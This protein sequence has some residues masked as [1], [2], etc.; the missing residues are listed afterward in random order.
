MKRCFI[1]VVLAAFGIVNAE[2]VAHPPAPVAAHAPAPV[3]AHAPAPEAPAHEAPVA[4]EPAT[5]APHAAEPTPVAQPLAEAP[6]MQ[7]AADT[8]TVVLLV[9]E[10][11]QK[12]KKR[13][14]RTPKNDFA[15]V[16]VPANFE[17]Q[18]RKVMPLDADGWGTNNLDTWWGRANLM[19]LTESENFVGKLH[20]RMYPGE[21]SEKK[22]YAYN[23]D[24]NRD[25]EGDYFQLYEAWAWHRGDYIN[26]KIG[27]WDNTTRFGSKTFGGYIDAK[28]D[29]DC[30]ATSH[31][32]RNPSCVAGEAANA[33]QDFSKSRTRRAKGFMSTY[34][35]ESMVQF[36]LN[37]FS[38][39]MSLDIALISSDENLNRGDLR[40]YFSFKDL[41]G[42]ENMELGLGYR[43]NV[44]DEIFS[45]YTDVTHTVDLGI[46]MPLVKDVGLLKSMSLF[47]ETALIGLDDHE[48]S[49]SRADGGNVPSKNNPAFP[50][51]GGLDIALYRGF[52]KVVIEAEYDGKR[53]NQTPKSLK[54]GTENDIRD[55]QG[56]IYVQKILNDR[57]TLNLGVQS[58]HNT[59]DFSFAARLQGR[60]N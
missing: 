46:R 5:P 13:G 18:G 45:R 15:V 47:L 14:S 43:S 16:D 49:E 20:L 39:N 35:P 1:A 33:R 4:V 2:A 11:P 44:F 31:D 24:G 40:A 50:V 8:N 29:K 3:A 32:P 17:I 60:I 41:A 57:F 10:Q 54:E 26:V 9:P 56:S 52:D 34:S 48:G 42:I 38:E 51:L 36:G 59:K 53:R 25:G 23:K 22:T 37:N 21:F 27:R 7:P 12:K 58:E 6:V 55:I 19:V 30:S 28:K